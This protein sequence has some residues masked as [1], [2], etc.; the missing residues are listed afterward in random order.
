MVE[1]PGTQDMA[2]SAANVA[3]GNGVV[4]QEVSFELIK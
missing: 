3:I 1:T 4:I 2:P